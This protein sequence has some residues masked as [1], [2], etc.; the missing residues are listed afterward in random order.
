MVVAA[1]DW[2]SE[3]VAIEVHGHYD[4]DTL[5]FD[6]A[7]LFQVVCERVC[8]SQNRR[9]RRKIDLPTTYH[10]LARGNESRHMARLLDRAERRCRT[11]ADLPF[12]QCLSCSA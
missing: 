4:S 11:V 8:V 7:L 2:T 10:K 1:A 6:E 3:P 12:R 9:R 5:L